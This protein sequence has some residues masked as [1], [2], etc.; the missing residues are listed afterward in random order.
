MVSVT[1]AKVVAIPVWSWLVPAIP[2]IERYAIPS[3]IAGTSPAIT[4]RVLADAIEPELI[5]QDLAEPLPSPFQPGPPWCVGSRSIDPL[6]RVHRMAFSSNGTWRAAL[7][8]RVVAATKHFIGQSHRLFTL[9]ST[10]F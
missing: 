7:R 8:Q 6:V 4:P 9:R 1:G 5:E 10:N 2:I 3:V